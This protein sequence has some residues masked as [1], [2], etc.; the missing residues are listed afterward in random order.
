MDGPLEAH[1]NFARWGG[2]RE[3]A[4]GIPEML[5]LNAPD[6]VRRSLDVR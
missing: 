6:C 3:W 5:P 4:K 2:F 1:T